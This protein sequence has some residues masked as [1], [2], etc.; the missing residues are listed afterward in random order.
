MALRTLYWGLL[1]TLYNKNPKETQDVVY[2]PR[3]IAHNEDP[4]IF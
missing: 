4:S 2:G 1:F 3:I